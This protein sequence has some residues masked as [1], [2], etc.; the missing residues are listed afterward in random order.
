M[1]PVIPIICINISNKHHK[2]HYIKD[3]CPFL[4]STFTAIHPEF[5][6]SLTD[7]ELSFINHLKYKKLYNYLCH[8]LTHLRLW[9]SIHKS[10]LII[11]DNI[12]FSANFHKYI[13]NIHIPTDCDILYVGGQCVPDYDI[14]VD[15]LWPCHKLSSYAFNLYYD[16]SYNNGNVYKRKTPLST[17]LL[18]LHTWCIPISRHLSSY[19][20][21]PKG[22]KKLLSLANN[23]KYEFMSLPINSFICHN[24]RNGNLNIYELFPHITYTNFNNY[25]NLYNY[26][27]H[28]FDNLHL[29]IKI[30]DDIFIED[31]FFNFIYDKNIKIYNSATPDIYVV[32]NK[33]SNINDLIDINNDNSKKIIYISNKS[34]EN[35][36]NFLKSINTFDFNIDMDEIIKRIISIIIAVKDLYYKYKFSSI[37]N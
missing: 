6:H 17:D 20:I 36:F 25:M 19:I 28:L 24:G 12:Y 14:N 7:N 31:K 34:L 2:L 29:S 9:Q 16:I 32:I 21:T 1:N 33:S 8:N 15:T 4:F 5:I 18:D 13:N 10:T 35:D 30:L 22:A 26:K 37:I 27:F 11:E 3:N 23:D